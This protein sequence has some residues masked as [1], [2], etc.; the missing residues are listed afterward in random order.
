MSPSIIAGDPTRTQTEYAVL[1]PD[2]TIVTSTDALRLER[3]DD[4]RVGGTHSLGSAAKLARVYNDHYAKV[5]ALQEAR[6]V[7]RIVTTS[8]SDWAVSSNA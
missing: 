3:Y 4:N 8:Y 5:G 6:P 1:L 2:G 7:S